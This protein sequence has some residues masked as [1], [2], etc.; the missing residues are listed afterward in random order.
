MRNKNNG[1]NRNYRFGRW[2][3]LAVLPGA[4]LAAALLAIAGI[5][6]PSSQSPRKVQIAFGFHVNLYHS[7][8]NDSNDEAGFGKDIRVIRH[9]VETLDRYN[10]QGVP[11]KG[12][13]DFDNMFS[14]QEILPRYAPDIIE[15]IRRRV[16]ENGDEVILMSYN[17]G[18]ASAMTEEELNDAV[19]WAVSNPW[20]SGV[21]DLFGEYGPIVR[22]QEMMTTPGNFSIYKNAGV[23]AVCLYY[24][25]TPF[26]AFRV[27]SRRLTLAEAHNPILYDHPD[28]GE[29]MA[30]IPTYNIGDLVENVSLKNWAEKLRREQING[31]IDK[32]LL[33]FVNF[34]AD[35]DFWSGVD[36]N[37]ILNW[38]PNTNGISGLIEEVKDLDYV[39]FTTVGDYL[40]SHPPE[41]RFHFG[42][43]TADGSFNGYNSWAEKSDSHLFWTGIQRNRRAHAALEKARKTYG[44]PPE[45]ATLDGILRESYLKRLRALSTTHFGMATPFLAPDRQKAA[46]SLLAELDEHSAKIEKGVV[47]YLRRISDGGTIPELEKGDSKYLGSFVVVRP[48][49]NRDVIQSRYLQIGAPEKNPEDMQLFVEGTGAGSTRVANLGLSKDANGARWLRIFVPTENG[50]MDGEYRLYGKPTAGTVE[51][52]VAADENGISNGKL[53]VRFDKDGKVEGIYL[54][55]VRYADAGSLTPYFRYDGRVI[56]FEPERVW[57]E[58]APDGMS[59]SVRVVGKTRGPKKGA[60]SDGY[61]DYTFTLVAD[62]PYLLLDGE[63]QYPATKLKDTVKENIPALARRADTD[64][65]ET[66]PA[67]IRFSP[68]S[69][70]NAPVRVLKHNYLGV[71]SEYALDYFRHSPEN[72]NLGNANNHVTNSYFGLVSGGRGMAVA[73]D[74]TVLSNFAFAP[75]K[76]EYDRA[77]D[78]FGVRANPFGAYHGEQYRPPTTGNGHGYEAAILAGEQYASSAPTYNGASHRIRIMVAFFDGNRI[79][80]KLEEELLAYA[81]PPVAVT[82][83]GNESDVRSAGYFFPPV[84]FTPGVS[85]NAIVSRPAMVS[86]NDDAYFARVGEMVQSDRS[87]PLGLKVRVF[88]ENVIASF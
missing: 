78:S 63:I 29:E 15:N 86:G 18:L 24:S 58:T 21:E 16:R 6:G 34:D 72:L 4:L 81:N 31:E 22:P 13:W 66:A 67:E 27:F 30:V 51:K 61:F 80:E 39:R 48:E 54:D 73:T 70:K 35:A 75:L 68:R 69:P 46:T 17:N 3:L 47:E 11:V 9:I 41:S 55:G 85:S 43:D 5:N 57:S 33:I 14:L 1:K 82:L 26:D 79:P 2:I 38:L 37:W 87:I 10:G 12:V 7:F 50:L 19:R 77:A 65:I 23:K 76:V 88:W 83:G 42:Q 60:V 28:T 20:K 45:L 49:E 44:D 25:A 56:D 59:G 36:L 53:E 71:E 64:W 40:E 74:N 32:D 8:R 62:R 84:E 52:R